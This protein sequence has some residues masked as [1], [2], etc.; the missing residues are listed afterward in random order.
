MPIAARIVLLSAACLLVV[1]AAGAAPSSERE[2]EAPGPVGPLKGSLVTPTA[3]PSAAVLIIPGSGPTDRNGNSPVGVKASTYRLLAEG[4]AAKGIATLRVDKRGMFGSAA[5]VKDPNSAT[6]ASYG[7]DV[8]A[9]VSVLRKA[10]GV[11]CVWVLGHSEG[12][13]VAL[14][15]AKDVPDECGLLLVSAPGRRMADILR[16]QLKENPANEPLLVHALPAI[17]ALEQGRHVQTQGMPPALMGLFRPAVQ[18]F[19]I[20]MLSL[21]PPRLVAGVDKP[22]L[23][24]QGQRDIQVTEAD[25]RLLKQGDPRATLVLLP[26]VNHVLKTVPSDDRQAN[27]ATYADPALPLA[28]GVVD[29][30]ADFIAKHKAG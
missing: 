28:P 24:L 11:S 1:S 13:L 22:V 30:I 25:A 10:T 14:T 4:L 9:W 17:A 5:A 27:L 7:E 29:A 21:D 12:G 3:A 20:S 19:L 26:A 16:T 23:I 18:D 8:K 15:S 2:L 6:F